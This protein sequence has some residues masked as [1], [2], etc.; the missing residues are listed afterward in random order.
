MRKFIPY[1]FCMLICSCGNSRNKEKIV[2]CQEGIN[3]LPLYG[4]VE[5]CKQQLKADKEFF[6][7]C[8]EMYPSR[9]EAAKEHVA[10]AW[11][12]AYKGDMDIATKRFNQAYLLDSLNADAYWGLGIIQGSKKLYSEAEVL[13]KR[14]LDLNPKNE[15]AW[16][17][18]LVNI[19]EQIW[20]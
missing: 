4:H 20:Q 18:L 14:S 7:R 13:F 12:H 16:F 17:C 8:D 5:K 6:I 19:K 9:A 15:R 1:I 10:M 11:N 3:L 2:E